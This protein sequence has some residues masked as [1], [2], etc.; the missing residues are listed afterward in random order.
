MG[1]GGRSNIGVADHLGVKGREGG[2]VSFE[3]LSTLRV[4]RGRSFKGSILLRE[5]L[6]GFWGGF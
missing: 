4:S 3:A 6:S 5:L 1:V 2:A